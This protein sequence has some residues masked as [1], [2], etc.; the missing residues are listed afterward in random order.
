MRALTIS[1]LLL[2]TLLT[3]NAE[4]RCDRLFKE[5]CSAG[6]SEKT[7][8]ATGSVSGSSSKQE[9]A[10]IFTDNAQKFAAKGR[11][12]A[13]SSRADKT[14]P[15]LIKSFGLDNSPDCKTTNQHGKCLDKVADI[16][17]NLLM[18]AM[19]NKLA[20][21]VDLADVSLE[22]LM[23]IL[24]GERYQ[25]AESD[26]TKQLL[27]AS[28]PAF[29]KTASSLIRELRTEVV[30]AA[31]RFLPDTQETAELLKKI[32]KVEYA[33]DQ[34]PPFPFDSLLSGV[35][36]IGALY[37]DAINK[38]RICRGLAN[39]VTSR[40]ALSTALAHEITHSIDPCTLRAPSKPSEPKLSNLEEYDKQ[41]PW[42]P[43]IEC[44]RKKGSFDA[45]FIAKEYRAE[46]CR[47]DQIVEAVPDFIAAEVVGSLI[48]KG[49]LPAA[50]PDEAMLGLKNALRFGCGSTDSGRNGDP[51][52]SI[53]IR[54][55][56]SLALQPDIR[57]ALQCG[58]I[59]TDQKYCGSV[60]EA[61]PG[62]EPNTKPTTSNRS[63]ASVSVPV[64][65]TSGARKILVR[66]Q[67]GETRTDLSY[68]ETFKNFSY[69]YREAKHLPVELRALPGKCTRGTIVVEIVPA[70]GKVRE[71]CLFKETTNARVYSKFANLLRW[72][73]LLN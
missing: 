27:A 41:S 31:K 66:A 3:A 46:N 47:E 48:K 35:S 71:S 67:I 10:R 20:G 44:L 55:E 54:V 14:L 24:Q 29:R 64:P 63:I 72:E 21:H 50:N 22:S 38:I 39:S 9:F 26:M 69:L 23:P 32:S 37:D 34:C 6:P 1:I 70:D 7:I 18:I 30:S 43:L 73:R 36:Q 25:K 52:S 59:P 61:R 17:G 2:F 12:L 15:S 5:T 28:N 8:D 4:D 60:A 13:E 62:D 65:K 51:H 19:S 58:A 57:K 56:R 53:E 45:K 42:A 40:F 11:K 16:F 33:D 49:K 68:S